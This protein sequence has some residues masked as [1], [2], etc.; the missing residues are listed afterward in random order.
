MVLSKW[1]PEYKGIVIDYSTESIPDS[2][3]FLD[4][5]LESDEGKALL[6]FVRQGAFDANTYFDPE[7][8]FPQEHF[9]LVMKRLGVLSGLAQ[10]KALRI[11]DMETSVRSPFLKGTYLT[12]VS[13]ILNKKLRAVRPRPDQYIK[14]NYK[15]YL[16]SDFHFP[17]KGQTLN[18]C[19]GFALRNILKYKFG[20]G[21][22]VSK[23]EKYIGKKPT[24]LATF[25]LQ[26]KMD[27]VLHIYKE[28]KYHLQTLISSL[29][30]GEPL[31]VSYAFWYTDRYGKRKS[32]AHVVAAYS[33]DEV[34]V[35]VSETV[36][37]RRIRIP[38]EDL[39]D[40]Q[41]YVKHKWMRTVYYN[42]QA[43]WTPEELRLEKEH[44]FLVGEF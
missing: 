9:F 4:M 21:V 37:N 20:I 3:L 41:G 13:R 36:T 28:K 14:N 29:Q 5:D 2:A 39:F 18:G 33:F 27:A 38:Y 32:V 11:C 22:Y 12:Y 6:Y 40:A 15:P 25:A 16:S 1:Y 31:A 8:T 35:W 42:P 7:G 43:Y 24:D 19:Y 17:L 30:H 34:G 26:Q 23:V 44:N 10:C